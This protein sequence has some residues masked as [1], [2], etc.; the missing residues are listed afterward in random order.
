MPSP[1]PTTL[2]SYKAANFHHARKTQYRAK[3]FLHKGTHHINEVAFGGVHRNNQM[4]SMN[5]NTIRQRK[6][7]VRGLKRENSGIITGYASITTS[8]Y[9]TRAY[10]TR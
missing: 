2:I 7:I 6:K 3:N 1:L 9:P 5:G 8:C 10:P 4:E